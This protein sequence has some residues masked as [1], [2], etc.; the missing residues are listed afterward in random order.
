M[1]RT[2]VRGGPLVALVA[3]G[4]AHASDADDG[5]AVAQRDEYTVAD[6]DWR[7]GTHVQV[8]FD[9]SLRHWK[10]LHDMLVE[11]SAI[12]PDLPVQQTL[13]EFV[14]WGNE[15]K[16][17]RAKLQG[18][19]VVHRNDGREDKVTIAPDRIDITMKSC[20]RN[21][22]IRAA[23]QALH[24]AFPQAVFDVAEEE[25]RPGMVKFGDDCNSD[26]K[27]VFDLKINGD[28]LQKRF[29][30]D[31]GH[32]CAH[33]VH[34]AEAACQNNPK[35]KAAM[36]KVKTVRCTDG[37]AAAKWRITLSGATLTEAIGGDEPHQYRLQPRGGAGSPRG[38]R[39][40]DDPPERGG[41]PLLLRTECRSSASRAGDRRDRQGRRS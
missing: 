40:L 20:E 6:F 31:P 22:G 25:I 29:G 23:A 15:S 7:F 35:I 41:E 2:I 18:V 19:R 12:G 37:G 14:N 3:A 28:D 30:N 24:D 1:A 33:A 21:D 5:A 39:G 32:V 17:V 13:G 11:C 16:T 4:A 38:A 10:T 8:E 36:G 34:W 27:F 9:H 26:A